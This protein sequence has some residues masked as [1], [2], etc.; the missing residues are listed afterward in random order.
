MHLNTIKD[1][2]KAA[3]RKRKIFDL[4]HSGYKEFNFNNW[5]FDNDS[6]KYKI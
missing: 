6:L 1:E 3:D 4:I 5:K 2:N